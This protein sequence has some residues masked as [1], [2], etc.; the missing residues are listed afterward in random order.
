MKQY[1]IGGAGASEL[2]ASIERAIMAAALRPGQQLPTVRALA[3]RV[4][5]SPATVAAAFAL[6]RARGLIAGDG[7]RGTTVSFMPPVAGRAAPALPANVHNLALG[8]PDPLLLPDLPAAV[9]GLKLV[10]RLYGAPA[11]KPELLRAAARM[12]EADGIPARDLAV[13]SG[14][15]D[16]IERI[17]AA[18]LRPGDRVAVEDPGYPDVTDLARALGLVARP[19]RVDDRGIVAADLARVLKAGVHAVVITP[20]AQNPTGATLDADRAGELRALLK[21]HPEVLLIHDDHAGPIAGARAFT[22]GAESHSR[23]AVV[24]SVS[25]FLGPDLRLAVT[26]GDA[27]TISRVTG[28]QRL[29]AG[30]VSHILQQLVAELLEDAATRKLV[31]RAAATYTARRTALLESLAQ[32]GI[33][34]HGRS[35]LN[36]WIPIA[37]ESATVQALMAAGWAVAAGERFRLESA[38]AVRVTIAALREDLAAGFAA[39]L[40]R[41]LNPDGRGRAA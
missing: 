27:L 1:P 20:R 2:A 6:L 8:N 28:R 11:N 21:A 7:R 40:A 19:V 4:K 30:W 25:K 26:A 16:A 5:L 18:H 24:R 29:G 35:G 17:F 10:R 33:G 36:V 15:F 23:W 41:A 34:A 37:E 3:A 32:H 12:F 14:A 39:T 38:P 22:L 13:T 9:A 31:Q